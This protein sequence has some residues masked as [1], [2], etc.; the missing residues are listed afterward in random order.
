MN[1]KKFQDPKLIKKIVEKLKRNK[2]QIS[3]MEVC[4]SHT[5]AIG[6]WGIRDLL[7]DNIKL[8]SG[9]GCPV[10]VTP[11]SII[12]SVIDLKDVTIAIFGDLMRVPGERGSLELA[13]AKGL[14][15]RIVYSPLDALKLAQE[16]ET[17]F[18]G[19]GFETTIPGI[20]YTIKEAYKNN[21][22]NYSVLTSLKV[23]PPAL[24]LLASADDINL[25]GFILP[26]HVSVVTGSNAYNFL[27]EKYN[28]GG[29]VT[30]FEPADIL[31][32]VDRL[33]QQ[34]ENNDAK[35]E[36]EY[37]RIVTPEG[38]KHTQEIMKEVL[39]IDD[40]IWRGIGEIP[41]SE[42]KIRKKY[43]DYDAAKKYNIN[44]EY[45][46]DKSGCR[47]GDVLKGNII[48][49]ECHLFGKSCTP[50]NPIGPCMVSSEGS[51]A[52]YYKYERKQ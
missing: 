13:R 25:N 51:C 3:L 10:C 38:N 30:G 5:M 15:V 2:R 19:I 44:I 49:P 24:E 11:M 33:I 52:A 32:S 23:V 37:S 22:T 45:K 50:S 4:G 26:G 18:V 7:P 1:I 39:E 14:D 41:K 35:I 9:P 46:E 8:I 6:K 48:P 29:V 47:C 21:I 27:P 42:L 34:V 40:G 31:V 12:D 16:K 28:I 17:V 36:N 43:S 20:A